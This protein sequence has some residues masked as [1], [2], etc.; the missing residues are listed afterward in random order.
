MFTLIYGDEGPVTFR[1]HVP[2]SGLEPEDARMILAALEP[3]LEALRASAEEGD[4]EVAGGAPAAGDVPEGRERRRPRGS[5]AGP[6]RPPLSP[7]PPAT[8][9]G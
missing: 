2:L 4:V 9:A 7:P 8:V 3:V 6:R 5:G 1:T